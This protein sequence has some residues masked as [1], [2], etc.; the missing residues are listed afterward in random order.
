MPTSCL[1]HLPDLPCSAYLIEERVVP[2]LD[3]CVMLAAHNGHLGYGLDVVAHEL[4]P[5][6]HLHPNLQS[7]EHGD[8]GGPGSPPPMGTLLSVVLIRSILGTVERD[9][10]GKG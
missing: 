7:K 6:K 2:H 4:S 1:A 10:M 3:P 5:F 8:A 9:P